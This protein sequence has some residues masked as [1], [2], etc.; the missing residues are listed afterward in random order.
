MN[1]IGLQDV[2]KID[3]EIIDEIDDI[4]KPYVLIIPSRIQMFNSMGIINNE[5]YNIFKNADNI[6]DTSIY[7][8][9]M[10]KKA[11]DEVKPLGMKILPYEEELIRR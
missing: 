7:I 6:H 5:E 9:S 2:L 1:N 10:L 4:S 11:F 8:S 3:V